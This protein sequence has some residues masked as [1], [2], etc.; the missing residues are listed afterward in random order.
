MPDFGNGALDTPRTNVGDATYL[1]QP[2]F[3]DI[4]QEASFQSP[5]KDSNLLQQ[6]RN[7]RSNGITLRTPR[8]RGPLADR[9]NL[10]PSVGGAEFT[11]LLKSATRNSVRRFGKENGVAVPNTPALD[12]IDEGDL[13]PVPRGDT[14]IYMGSR[15]QSYLEN[16][17]PEV[18][19]SSA[20]ST[21]L[22]VPRRRG[23][24]KGP[25]QDGNQ[26]SLREQENVIDRIEKENFGL[27]LKIHFL[28]EALRKAGPGFSEAALKENTELKVDKVTM[29]RELHKYKKHL[30]TAEKDLESYRQQMLEVQEKAKRKYANQSNQAEMDKLQRLLED[31][32]ADIEDLQRQ[33]Q[34][35]KGSNDQVEKLQDDIGDLEADIREKDRQLTE[36]QDELEDLKDQMETLKDKATEAEEKAKD[37]Q[38]KMVALKEKAQHNDELDDAKDTIQDLEHSIRRLEEQVEDAKSK[39]EEAMAEKDRAE[40]DLEELQDDMANKS[41]VTKGLSRQ[42]EEKVARL[43]EELD[44]SGQEYATLEKEHNKV[45]QENSSLQ[46][47][48]KELRKSQERF[49][50][51]R[52]SLS[53]RIEELEADLNDRT[54]EK[55]ILQSRHDSLLSESK[56][57]QSEIEKLEGECQ[58]LEEGLAEEREHALGI[59][60]DIRGQ[61][62]AEMDRLNDEISDLQ[63]EIREKDNLYD[64]DS[65]KW[66]TDKQNLESERKRA[67]EKAAGL[68]RTIDRLKEV[69]GNISD[70]ESKLQIAIQSEIER[71]RSEEG[72]LTRQIEDLQDA[73]ETRQTLLTNLRNEL[74]AV[75]DELRQTQ[76]DHQ[77]QT[78]KVAALED[79]VDVL[80][81]TLDDEQS[82]G[83][84]EA[85]AA[86]RECEDLKEQL[87][88]LRQRG[89]GATS[90]ELDDLKEELKTWRQ[91][92]EAAQAAISTSEQEAKL[93]TESMTRMKWQLSDANS[94]LDKVS[95]EKQS[96]QDQVAKINT[97]LHS[98]STSLAEV[99]AERDE[100]DGEIRRTKLYDNETLRVD[101]ERLDLRTAKLKL[102]NEVRR[103]KDENKALIEQRDVIEKNLEDEIEKAA[104]EEERLGQEILQLQT[105]LRTSSSTD[106]HDLAA[107]RRTIRELERRVED[108]EAQ[109]N[110]TR[111]LPNNFEGNSELSLIRKDLSA[112]RQKELEF[113]Q[114]ET[115]NRDVVKGLKRQIADLERQVHE[116]EVS[117]LI[118]S[119]KS[120][121]TDSGRKTEV[122][123]LRSQLSAAQKSIHDLKSKNRE[124]ERKAMQV[125]QD[126][127]RQLDD[128][129]DQK[130]VLEEVL[131]EARQQAEETAA[132]HERAL[133]R[134]KHQLDKAERERNTLATLQPST[135]KHDRQLR[136]NQAE[137]EN[138][139]HDVL[140]QQELIDNL[141]AS[142]ASLRRKLERARN[143]RAAFRMSAEKLQK[144]LERV[145]AAAVAARAGTS[146]R[147]SAVDRKALDLT[148]EGADQA[149]ETVIRA[150]ESADERHKKELRG[151]LMQM[152]WMQARFKREASL[153]AD[154]A[155][156]KKFLQLQ[157]DVA[158][159]CNKAQI[160]ELEDIRTNLLGNKKA[161]ALP[162][163]ATAS[164]SSATKPTLKTFLVMARFIARV[165]LSAN[166]WAQQEVVRRKIVSAT[167]EQRKVKRSRQLKVVKAEA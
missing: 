153:R 96:L 5:P 127:Q 100:L 8:Q 23:G 41:V 34:Q 31:R 63:A 46:S 105:K 75:R 72:L 78:R 82:A 11:P 99:K 119:P 137:M 122:T 125:S 112:A 143:E 91:R 38:R 55:N 95:K 32:E 163:H 167:E 139:E 58:E 57:L 86:K 59:E 40:N 26:L 67:E 134:M 43:Q 37:A 102:D 151:M 84:Y 15:N 27:K 150:A 138:L 146:D 111:Q 62:K 85:E 128:L 132:Q 114:K 158:N 76:I 161:L 44:Q 164:N 53:T 66:E 35:Q 140:Q 121:A 133:R 48:V 7:G 39:M 4:T 98:V 118:A 77:A 6:L 56:S 25:L 30:T 64:N 155:Y 73:L 97:E 144:D 87:R 83:R 141:A 42:I 154:A 136:K 103:L 148:I 54:N 20:T 108:Y 92:A 116:T 45:V 50:R 18:D 60:K 88:V 166:N 70:T 115:S 93:S 131:E 145:K 29:Q 65:E 90:H 12:K 117:R 51:E 9:R 109:L 69:E 130:I 113:L 165:R 142:E 124:A 17:I 3:G 68:Q 149:L 74:S 36:R 24:D 22:T 94:Q 120:S 52:D 49:D 1:G 21:P 89:N 61:Y 107:A 28:E 159:A 80:Q 156:A 129:E 14:S 110:N 79:E 13:T 33:L 101:Q 106:N 47:A 71:H 162:S 123:E 104:E 147:R 19:T 2:D 10:P 16:T 81:T 160:R 152:E 157:L 126:F 135:S